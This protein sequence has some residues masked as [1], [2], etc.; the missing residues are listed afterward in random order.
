MRY[1]LYKR[2]SLYDSLDALAFDRRSC[3]LRRSFSLRACSAKGSR[4][5]ALLVFSKLVLY[6]RLV[7]VA[8]GAVAVH[9]C[10]GVGLG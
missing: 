1:I 5:L 7:S 9:C 6:S 10:V 2:E 4:T 8:L 3:P